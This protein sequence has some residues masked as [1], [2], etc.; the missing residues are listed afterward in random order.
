[1]KMSMNRKQFLRWSVGAVMASATFGD[2]IAEGASPARPRGLTGGRRQSLNFNRQWRFQLG[3]PPGAEAAAFSD[4]AW[5]E[6]GLPHS[7]SLPYFAAPQFYVGYGWYRKPLTVPASWEGQRIHLEFDGAFQV[8]ELFVNGRR[9]GEHRGGYTGFTF[10]I[11]DFVHTGRNLIAVRVNNVWDPRL[12]PRAGEHTFSGGLYRN[13][14]LVVTAPL[15]VAWY[16]TH[17]TTPHVS[18]EAGTVNVK[19]EVV[20]DTGAAKSATVRT[21]IVDREGR[22][23]GQMQSTHTVEARSS[24]VFDQTSPAIPDP[25]LWHPDN[26]HLYSVQIVV[27]DGGLAVDDFLSPLGFRWFEFTPDRGFFLNGEHHYLKGA[28]VHQ[29]HAGWGDGITNTG[30]R[31]DVQMVKDAGMDFIRGSHYPHS[32]AFA[33]ACDELGVLFWSENCFWGTGGFRSPWGGSA[34]PTD[35]ADEAGFEQSLKDSLRDMIRIHRNHPSIVVWSMDN[36]VFFSARQVMPKVRRLLTE[37]V[38]YTHALDPTRP[39]AIGGCQ[40]G[41]IDKLGDVA[42]YNGDGARLFPSPGIPNVVTEYGS[43]IADR[44]G[45]YE[46]GWGDLPSTPGAAPTQEGSWRL[47]WRSGEALWCAFDHGSLAG[48]AFG[49]MGFVDYFR[50][51]KRQW[52]WYRNTYRGIPPPEWPAE[53]VAAGLRLTADKTVLQSVDGTDDAHLVVTVVDAAGKALSNSRPSR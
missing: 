33:K 21:R 28:N 47:P 34:Y 22:A 19:T 37:L 13:V 44:P 26:P 20:N 41:D 39:A 18:K 27:L 46:P 31:R 51:P 42:G 15:H 2:D 10:D 48:R 25:K 24:L 38:S 35:P 1:M 49:S 17:I 14:R 45:K 53:G 12:A 11:T 23:V 16:G 29:D 4:G 8:S 6:V 32:P 30:S 43:T 3:D 52:Y 36:E 9:V 7:F 5:S 40:R 50:L